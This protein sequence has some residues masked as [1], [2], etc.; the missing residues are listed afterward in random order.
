MKYLIKQNNFLTI[1]DMPIAL[2]PRERMKNEGK[3]TLSD[4]ELVSI[5]IGAGGKDNNVT[6]V[7]RNVITVLDKNNNASYEDLLSVKGLGPAK[8]SLICASLEIGRRRTT[9]KKRQILEPVDAFNLIRHYSTRRQEQFIVL[10]LNSAYEVL[11]VDVASIGTVNECLIHPREVFSP[12]I[13]HNAVA[14]ILTHNH[15]SGNLAASDND[16]KVTQRM[17]SC[18][19]IIG[20][21]V[22]DHIIFDEESF[23][24]MNDNHELKSLEDFF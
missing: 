4:E 16:F 19:D 20:I 9:N 15:P 23:H 24:S 21:K 2:R 18:G 3:E 14:V 17:R 11:S 12:A 1:S 13:S 6:N 22:I 5:L 7:A 8:A 10:S